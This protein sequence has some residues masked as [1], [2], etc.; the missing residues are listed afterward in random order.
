MTAAACTPTGWAA[1]DQMASRVDLLRTLK[2]LHLSMV[3]G[4]DIAHVAREVAETHITL[5]A[6]RRVIAMRARERPNRIGARHHP[7]DGKSWA[8]ARQ[9]ATNQVIP[10]PEPARCGLVNL[11]NDVIA[12]CNRAVAAAA[13][14][15]PS[16]SAQLKRSGA[17]PALRRSG[18]SRMASRREPAPKGSENEPKPFAEIRCP[19]IAGSH[20]RWY[21]VAQVASLLGYGET[22]VRML[23]ISGDLRSLKDGH[24]RR[25][26]PE[27]VDDYVRLRASQA[28]DMWD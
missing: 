26:L 15:D 22:K 18:Q 14:L 4:V 9:I 10:L 7:Y 12:A 16:E 21:T 23:I 17:P 5:T 24:S 25:V 1:P 28:K 3:G 19:R 13:P 8:S 27:W 11:I 6:P 20:P 2:C